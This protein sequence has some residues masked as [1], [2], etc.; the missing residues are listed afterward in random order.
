MFTYFWLYILLRMMHGISLSL[1]LQI[2]LII[3]GFDDCQ[4]FTESI[5]D[6]MPVKNICLQYS[7]P[8][9]PLTYW[10]CKRARMLVSKHGS[11]LWS[12]ESLMIDRNKGFFWIMMRI[13]V[14]LMNVPLINPFTSK[15]LVSGQQP[16]WSQADSMRKSILL[17]WFYWAPCWQDRGVLTPL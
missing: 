5:T 12:S 11:R 10:D 17:Y 3:F 8:I 16:R 6:D 2:K 4:S 13:L 7:N 15:A 14:G 1:L 9:I